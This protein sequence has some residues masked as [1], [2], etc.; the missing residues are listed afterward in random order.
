MKVRGALLLLLPLVFLSLPSCTSETPT[1]TPVPEQDAVTYVHQIEVTEAKG[2]A[3]DYTEYGKLVTVFDPWNDRQVLHRYRLHPADYILPEDTA[4]EY[5]DVTV[6]VQRTVCLS[7][8]HLGFLEALHLEDRII[9][10]DE[11]DYIY[12]EALRARVDQDEIKEYGGLDDMR[13]EAMVDLWPDLI[14]VSPMEASNSKA[15]Q[16]REAGLPF[17]FNIE[18]QEENILARAEWIKFMA[19]FF[20]AEE[21]ANQH[22]EAVSERYKALCAMVD[23]VTQRP[24]VLPGGAFKGT[25]YMPAGESFT[26]RLLADAGTDYHWA[27]T[28]GT[29][30][31]SLAMEE[32]VDVLLEADVWVNPN[33]ASTLEEMLDR[34]ERYAI[35]ES[36][37]Q[38]KVYNSNARINEF[39]GND[40]WES[41]VAWPDKI[42][43]DLVAIFHPALMPDHKLYYY[44]QLK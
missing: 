11:T 33:N 32:V 23:T 21:A 14:M 26:A 38:G 30:S 8:T 20:D 28:E 39:G 2:F 42:L 18:W 3:V 9:G 27:D 41:A 44:H 6:P 24:R 36:F 34:E 7:T 40:Y 1:P 5:I 4:N 17:A 12:H 37:K 29:G 19:L 25:W 35:F 10:V 22:F 15:Q 43:A 16:L 31:L 13:L